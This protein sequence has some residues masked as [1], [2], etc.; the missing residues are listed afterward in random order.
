MRPTKLSNFLGS[1][2]PEKLTDYL[3][4]LE[5]D[6]KRLFS[7][8][9]DLLTLNKLKVGG[10]NN[11]AEFSDEGDFTFVSNAGLAFGELWTNDNTAPT[12]IGAAEI[13]VQFVNFQK[14]GASNNTTPSSANNHITIEKTGNFL[15]TG[16][17]CVESIGGGAADKV[18]IQIRKN[19]GAT[20]YN[21]MHVHRLLAGG[22]GDV[23]SIS[24]SGMANFAVND[25]V[26][27]WVTN[28]DNASNF[29]IDEANLSLVQT[30]G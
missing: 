9:T 6:L 7:A 21:N 24:V 22:G 26:E 2:K 27:V 5:A 23:G 28:E 19:N 17:F 30:G 29:I 3:K 10:T 20:S 13:F 14:E 12:T 8:F 25:T 11:Y 18:T 4:N 15:V 16:S 1:L